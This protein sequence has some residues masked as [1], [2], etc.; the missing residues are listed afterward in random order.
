MVRF[1]NMSTGLVPANEYL[2]NKRHGV[3]AVSLH[4][5]EY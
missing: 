2:E 1:L 3:R 4:Y 5:L